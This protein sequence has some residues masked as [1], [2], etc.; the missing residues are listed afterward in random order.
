MNWIRPQLP[1]GLRAF[2]FVPMQARWVDRSFPYQTRRN[3]APK[4]E[5]LVIDP[6]DKI[7]IARIIMERIDGVVAQARVSTPATIVQNLPL[8]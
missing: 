4:D 1:Q 2:F 6:C 7:D 5:K 3:D 8:K